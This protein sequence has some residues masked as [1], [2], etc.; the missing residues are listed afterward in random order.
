MWV[1]S[2]SWQDPLKKKM[3]THSS[4]LAWRIP[5]AEELIHGLQSAGLQRVRRDWSDFTHMH[6]SR[7]NTS[8]LYPAPW[9]DCA[10]EDTR[11]FTTAPTAPAGLLEDYF[12]G[13]SFCFPWLLFQHPCFAEGLM[14]ALLCDTWKYNFLGFCIEIMAFINKVANYQ[15]AEKVFKWLEAISKDWCSLQSVRKSVLGFLW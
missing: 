10:Q 15:N 5:W 7:E 13:S 6:S 14:I 1:P 4:I 12:P 11:S 9:A 3:A 8:A 2:L